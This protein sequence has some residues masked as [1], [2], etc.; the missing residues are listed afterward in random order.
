MWYP[1]KSR[2]NGKDEGEEEDENPKPL[3]KRL[4]E[5]DSADIR[6]KEVL[7][8][9]EVACETSAI[10]DADALLKLREAQKKTKTAQK[11]VK[12]QQEHI[13]SIVE[14]KEAPA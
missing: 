4:V 9:S 14:E 2:K 1:F 3:I 12:Q 5:P 6:A 7:E 13:S 11:K 8:A 10:L